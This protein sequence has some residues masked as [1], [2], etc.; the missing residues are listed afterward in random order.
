MTEIKH[1]RCLDGWMWMVYS[2][3][4][5]LARMV[6]LMVNEPHEIQDIFQMVTKLKTVR[7]TATNTH[8]NTMPSIKQ[9]CVILTKN[10]ANELHGTYI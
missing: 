3:V 5:S 10:Q 2:Q 4:E 6:S 7:T 8:T 1:Y 9:K